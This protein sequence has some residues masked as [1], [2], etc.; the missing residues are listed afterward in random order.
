MYKM[1]NNR[2]ILPPWGTSE[3]TEIFLETHPFNL[4]FLVLKYKYEPNHFK[5]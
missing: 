4:T 2:E 3:E 1:N 5:I